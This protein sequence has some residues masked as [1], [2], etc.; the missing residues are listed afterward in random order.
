MRITMHICQALTGFAVAAALAP[1]QA[2]AQHSL[3]S[4]P[5]PKQSTVASADPKLG[6]VPQSGRKADGIRASL[7]RVKL[8]PGFKI[9]VYAIVPDAHHLAVSPAYDGVFVGTRKSTVWVLTIPEG[10]G[11]PDEVKAFAPSL[12]FKA[13]EGVCSTSDGFLLVVE[14]NRI[15]AISTMEFFEGGSMARVVEVVPQGELVPSR[16][17]SSEY[18]R[19][20]CRVGSDMKLY[21][22]LGP[23][24]LSRA[25]DK[26]LGHNRHGVGGVIRLDPLDGRRREVYV[27]GVCSPSSMEFNPKDN[28]LWITEVLPNGVS[29]LAN[30]GSIKRATAAGKS[31][32]CSSGQ[33]NA[34]V[35]ERGET[36]QSI[37][38]K[39]T[40]PVYASVHAQTLGLAFYTG[41]QFP[42]RYRGGLFTVQSDLRGH[43]IGS[44]VVF[45]ALR[46]DGTPDK[47]EVF[48]DGWLESK[49]QGLRERLVDVA[50]LP[51][52]S[53]LVSD[54][55]AGAIYKIWY[56][57]R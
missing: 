19:R 39:V 45:S 40:P 5:E 35:G 9:D 10:E 15:L 34:D 41:S 55:A 29:G 36:Q 32:A 54:E 33:G 23:P 37:P 11:K 56:E 38:A 48:A 44:R 46:T 47:T 22:A 16:R 50:Q 28:T 49:A 30:A 24:P 6:A 20:A 52:G 57:G 27:S 14:Q 2:T 42:E 31:F 26:S 43:T 51:D 13:P 4:A 18:G 25:S 21:V 3:D 7:K 53:L 1:M 12:K 8:P 17:A